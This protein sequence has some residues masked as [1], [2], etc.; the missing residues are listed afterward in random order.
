M[1]NVFAV[2]SVGNSLVTFLNNTYPTALRSQHPCT[3]R[4]FSSANIHADGNDATN[5]VSLYLYRVTINEHG[6][7]TTRQN[8]ISPPV[9]PLAVDLHYL[10]TVWSQSAFSENVILAWT[11]RQLHQ[12]PV[13]DLSSLTQDA[14]WSSSD[15]VQIVPTDMSTED[16]MRI[17]DAL[18]P[19][20]RLSVAYVAR[21]VRL[22]PDTL[23]EARPVVATRLSFGERGDSP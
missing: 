21:T 13:L 9:F 3:F 12:N 22:D 20:Y 8:G 19:P 2:H 1:A 7:N 18:Q 23:P 4:L 14:Q 17:W 6:R 16:M 10:V 11:I 5:Q 15:R